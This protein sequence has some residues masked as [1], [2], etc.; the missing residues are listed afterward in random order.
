MPAW[1]FI[2]NHGGVLVAV[3]P[4]TE[5]HRQRDFAATGH[6]RKGSA[7]DRLRL[8]GGGVYNQDPTR[9]DQYLYGE[10]GPTPPM[11]RC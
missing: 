5:D 7:Q 9:A 11:D 6:Y 4:A 10:P 1:D 3:F 2:T 8:G